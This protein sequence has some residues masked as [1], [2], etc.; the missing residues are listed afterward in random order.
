M[1]W[2]EQRAFFDIYL[3]TVRDHPVYNII[4]DELRLAFSNVTR[5]TIENFKIVSPTETFVLFQQ[6]PNPIYITFD[7]NLGSIANLSR[8]DTI[9]W[10]DKTSRLANFAYITYNE[11]DYRQLSLTYGNPGTRTGFFPG[12]R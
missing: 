11:T 8:S 5:P 9:Y 1:S 10:T 7:E 12:K 2:L 3:E 4:Q 6:S